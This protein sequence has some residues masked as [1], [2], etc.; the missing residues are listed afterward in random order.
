MQ[1][2]I[3]LMPAIFI[4]ILYHIPCS[5]SDAHTTLYRKVTEVRQKMEQL[6][7]RMTRLEARAQAAIREVDQL[8]EQK[9]QSEEYRNALE[10]DIEVEVMGFENGDSICHNYDSLNP[11]QKKSICKKK[12][13]TLSEVYSFEGGGK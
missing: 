1:F 5:A 13:I 9:R 8:K 3:F 11:K 7:N 12:Y 2:K 6:H 10:K 4:S